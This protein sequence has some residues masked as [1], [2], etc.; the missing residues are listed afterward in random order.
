MNAIIYNPAQMREELKK[1]LTQVAR[2]AIGNFDCGLPVEGVVG[3]AV[4][5]VEKIFKKVIQQHAPI[6]KPADEKLAAFWQAA[7][8]A[9]MQ[10]TVSVMSANHAANTAVTD[11]VAATKNGYVWPSAKTPQSVAMPDNF[12]KREDKP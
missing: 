1:V 8:L 10:N 5:N 6:A 4:A 7:Y 12:V 2:E 11:Y 9:Q 3:A